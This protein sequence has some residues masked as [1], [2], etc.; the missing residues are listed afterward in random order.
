ML[1]FGPISQTA[2]STI[3]AGFV[4]PPPPVILDTHDGYLRRSRRQRAV[5]AAQRRREAERLADAQALR[6]ELEAALGMAADVVDDVPQPA[7]EA[8]QEAVAVVRALP[9]ITAPRVDF[10]AARA[11]IADLL[12]AIDAAMKA[13][14]L[15]D[16]DEEVE[17]LLRAL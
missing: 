17:M 14:A 3:P 10:T 15:A 2:I 8:V 7:V 16:D 4:P 13:K 11:A 5:E 9:P 1:G 6:L 12:A